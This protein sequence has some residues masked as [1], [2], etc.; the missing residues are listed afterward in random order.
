MLKS[1][2]IHFFSTEQFF[3][4][5]TVETRKAKFELLKTAFY[6]EFDEKEISDYASLL[7]L[8]E[9]FHEER[10][11]SKKALEL[12]RLKARESLPIA[13][14]C[15]S[16]TEHI[17]Q[18][19]K[20]KYLL[21]SAQNN[22]HINEIFLNCLLTF[23]NINEAKLLIGRMT[24]NKNGFQ[25]D[26][27]NDSD[28][29]YD[30]KIKPYLVQGHIDLQGAHFLADSNVIPTAKNPLSG[31]ESA[32]GAGIH[33]IIPHTKIAMQMVAALKNSPTKIVTSTG[34]V[35][36]IN[37]IMRKHGAAAALE[38]N[39]GAVFVDTTGETP[40]IRH[41]E[42]MPE[43]DYFHDYDRTYYANGDVKISIGVITA[44]QPGDIHA[45]KMT[46]ENRAK[47]I[48]LASYLKPAFIVCHDLLDFS[49]NNHH[50]I[51]DCTH[52]HLQNILQ[53]SVQN[54]LQ[55]MAYFIDDLLDK[56]D[57][58]IY[59]VESNHDLALMTWL[60]NSDFKLDSK[61]ALV[62][63]RCMLAL[64]EH[65]ERE[66]NNDFNM[67]EYAYRNIANSENY[68]NTRLKF[69]RVD[70]SLLLSGV[71]MGYHGHNGANGSKG[72]PMQFKKLGIALNTGHTHSPSIWGKV[73]TA[74]VSASLELGYNIGASSWA[75]AHIVTYSN[76]QRQI[77]FT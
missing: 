15:N 53:N 68:D 19:P 77:L 75:I 66:G 57:S 29:W 73:Y 18:L 54:D 59:V 23:C 70:E 38:H 56:T 62:Y 17:K 5:K 27:N 42:L 63:L 33:V 12:K 58:S 13:A 31:F 45:E 11:A 8:L 10:K 72:S 2:I 74:G 25:K 67:L 36:L 64:Y 60:K 14:G 52:N 35:T 61:N 37:Y 7:P 34:A 30:K 48:E 39:M 3:R 32:T 40:T 50:N 22:T 76:G 55:I 46:E 26:I 71:E 47:I 6:Q 20:G 1:E 51:K 43:C 28:L 16:A 65:Q 49:T 41:I 44:L 4:Q 24:Y 69:N 9:S 21:T